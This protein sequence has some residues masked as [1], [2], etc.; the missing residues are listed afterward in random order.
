M[1]KKKYED[2]EKK[3]LTFIKNNYNGNE[4][5]S[6]YYYK[7][8]IYILLLQNKKSKTINFIKYRW[9]QIQNNNNTHT[10]YYKDNNG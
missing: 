7:L 3:L 1:Q 8:M 2:A 9:K 5:I 10:N 6:K 4:D